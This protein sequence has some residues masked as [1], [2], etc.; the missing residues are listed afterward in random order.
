MSEENP[1]MDEENTQTSQMS[2]TQA[3]KK[4]NTPLH[5]LHSFKKNGTQL[6]FCLTHA[7]EENSSTQ[8]NLRHNWYDLKRLKS[9]FKT[10]V[11]SVFFFCFFGK[12]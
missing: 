1:P 4:I 9:E 7:A 12:R 2:P 6:C 10:F 5:S 3:N 11:D 8:G